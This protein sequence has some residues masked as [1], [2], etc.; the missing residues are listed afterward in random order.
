MAL[1]IQHFDDRNLPDGW[2]TMPARRP[3]GPATI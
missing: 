1:P 3:G 2:L